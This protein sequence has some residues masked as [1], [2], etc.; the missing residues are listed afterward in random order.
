[1]V[2]FLTFL[3]PVTAAFAA[4]FA[5]A[6]NDS[7]NLRPFKIDL[8][9]EVPHLLD[10][11]RSTRLPSSP[12]Y[13]VGPDKGIELDFLTTLRNEWLDGFNWTTQEAAL[14]ESVILSGSPQY[15]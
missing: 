15:S 9:G 12:L 8:G 7:F 11:V 1:M 6:A 14:N 3:F 5:Y 13:P 4:T 10:L 2:L